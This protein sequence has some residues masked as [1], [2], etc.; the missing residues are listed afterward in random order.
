MIYINNISH[1]LNNDFLKLFLTK[2]LKKPKNTSN[3]YY[4]YK[5]LGK[6][7]DTG[8]IKIMMKSRIISAHQNGVTPLKIVPAFTFFN[9]ALKTNTFIPTGGV[10]KLI[11]VTT[12]TTMPNQTRSKPKLATSG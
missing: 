4:S 10:I 5:N 7:I 1:S 2:C 12:T 11:S 6:N 8:T 9:T 3:L